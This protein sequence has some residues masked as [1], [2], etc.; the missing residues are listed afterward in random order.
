MNAAESGLTKA[1]APALPK[2]D[3]PVLEAAIA[4]AKADG[5]VDAKVITKAEAKL[6]QA[7]KRLET[8]ERGPLRAAAEKEL[9]DQLAASSLDLSALKD[10]IEEAELQLVSSTLI[11]TA[12]AALAK[13]EL[14][15]ALEGG[16][17]DREKLAVA[18]ATAKAAGVEEEVLAMVEKRLSDDWSV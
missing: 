7:Q 16:V 1:M 15:L 14:D 10:A 17:E 13:Q 3:V 12:K 4:A 8:T 18:L 6:A 11:G 9:K 5:N 2:L